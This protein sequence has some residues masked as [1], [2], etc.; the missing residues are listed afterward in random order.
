MA[1]TRLAHIYPHIKELN[2]KHFHYLLI[3]YLGWTAAPGLRP[4]LKVCSHVYWEEEHSRTFPVTWA[5]I[6]HMQQL[7]GELT[8]ARYQLSGNQHRGCTP[9][10]SPHFNGKT[11]TNGQKHNP[12]NHWDRGT[13]PSKHD[14]L[15]LSLE[16]EK[17]EQNFG[18]PALPPTCPPTYG[19]ANIPWERWEELKNICS[20]F[21]INYTHWA[22]YEEKGEFLPLLAPDCL[23]HLTIYEQPGNPWI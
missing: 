6:T 18:L 17:E 12:I 10:F 9:L 16:K 7:R 22:E 1:S 8:F 23:P 14:S 11:E 15:L 13:Q 5:P 2:L 19:I 21:W 3:Y 20:S 4:L